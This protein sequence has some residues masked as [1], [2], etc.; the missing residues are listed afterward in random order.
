MPLAP[1]LPVGW[2]CVLAYSAPTGL[3]NERINPW[4]LLAWEAWIIGQCVLQKLKL[5]RNI[6]LITH[7]QE[8]NAVYRQFLQTWLVL[9]LFL[10][11]T[12]R[13]P[14]THDAGYP[15]LARI[16]FANMGL[17]KALPS[18]RICGIGEAISG[19]AVG[20]LQNNRSTSFKAPYGKCPGSFRLLSSATYGSRKVVLTP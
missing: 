15:W 14:T 16:D 20:R 1:I 5:L 10:P 3:A 9:W 19:P 2:P 18:I 13:H 6:S 8:T 7:E 12:I 17:E 4:R 11:F